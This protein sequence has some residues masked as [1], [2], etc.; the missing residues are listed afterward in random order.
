MSEETFS[1]DISPDPDLYIQYIQGET[2]LT[3]NNVLTG[4][5]RDA[6][7]R[8]FQ[9]AIFKSWTL[10]TRQSQNV[11]KLRKNVFF[12]VLILITHGEHLI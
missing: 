4:T 12:E 9:P 5:K 10:R 7:S 8:T 11:L 1:G 3:F 2:E 6:V